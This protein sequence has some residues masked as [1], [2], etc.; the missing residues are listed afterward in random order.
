VAE[1]GRVAEE[2]NRRTARISLSPQIP[3]PLF[4]HLS[5]LVSTHTLTLPHSTSYTASYSTTHTHLA[6]PSHPHHH[7]APAPF[8]ASKVRDTKLPTPFRGPGRKPSQH[9]VQY[10]STSTVRP[11][12]SLSLELTQRS[13]I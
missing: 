7:A 3:H 1:L 4:L 13:V 8:L 9:F 5:Y 2:S 12:H 6:G 11:S 10:P